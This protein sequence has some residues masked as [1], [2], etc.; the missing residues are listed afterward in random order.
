MIKQ[1]QIKNV[2]FESGFLYNLITTN[3]LITL[4]DDYMQLKTFDVL[5]IMK[6]SP[7][8]LFDS[9]I[10]K[11]IEASAYSLAYFPDSKLE[12][13]I[14][15]VISLFKNTQQPDSY[16]NTYYQH[17]E[18][19]NRFTSL[20]TTYELYCASSL[21][22]GA[23][24]YYITTNKIEFLNIMCRYV[25]LLYTIF[26][27]EKGKLKRYTGHEGIALALVKLYKVTLNKDYL[28]LAEF[29]ILERS[30]APIYFNDNKFSLAS[31]YYLTG[32]SDIAYITN[33]LTLQ[34]FCKKIYSQITS[35]DF[36]TLDT[37]NLI[38][39]AFFMERMFLYEKKGEYIDVLEKIVF[40]LNT[41][42][43]YPRKNLLTDNLCFANNTRFIASLGNY[44][45]A[46]S[47]EDIYVNLYGN[48]TFKHKGVLLSQ[49]TSYPYDSDI[50][51]V[52]NID[53]AKSFN[54]ALR[55]PSNFDKYI[56]T[57][58]KKEIALEIVD[59]Y[60]NINRLFNDKDELHLQLLK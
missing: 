38:G 55:I 32:L 34:T 39:L 51:F 44:A 4:S 36:L 8:Y 9:Y 24:A 23:V 16:L 2:T 18:I 46:T 30:N 28:N 1:G 22:E 14:D 50:T 13:Q 11:W 59:G 47:N 26:G 20:S 15:E 42:K 35:F 17:V 21:I 19:E 52:I 53:K 33:N 49:K 57:I 48:S 27:N 40:S 56:L 12:S 54:L 41:D 29:F 6:N 3:R 58:N 31:L 7:T 37:C 43:P 60:I 25:D 10:G 5:S 45:Y